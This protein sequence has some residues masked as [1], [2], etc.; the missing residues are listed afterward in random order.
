MYILLLPT[1]ILLYAIFVWVKDIYTHAF[2]DS[3]DRE[4]FFRKLITFCTFLPIV[5][6]T[7]FLFCY[8]VGEAIL[9][10]TSL[11]NIFA[12]NIGG[13][14][15]WRAINFG[16]LKIIFI[17]ALLLTSQYLLLKR[18]LSVN[19]GLNIGVKFLAWLISIFF[20]TLLVLDILNSLSISTSI[21]FGISYDNDYMWII[22]LLIVVPLLFVKG[23][24]VYN[25]NLNSLQCLSLTARILGLY[26][27]LIILITL[28]RIFVTIIGYLG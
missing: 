6:Q 10:S 7:V 19:K 11:S 25:N 18:N 16:P 9:L 8:A 22:S 1:F 20:P 12:F 24:W 5:L 27:L 28:P 14:L 21:Q 15:K 13:D 23:A 3:T 4:D 26:S 17:G 2:K